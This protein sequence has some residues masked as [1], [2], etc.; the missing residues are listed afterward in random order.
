MPWR[1]VH[2]RSNLKSVLCVPKSKQLNIVFFFALAYAL[3][4]I[5]LRPICPVFLI[6]LFLFTLPLF[7]S[8]SCLAPLCLLSCSTVTWSLQYYFG[9]GNAETLQLFEILLQVLSRLSIWLR[10]M[11]PVLFYWPSETKKTISRRLVISFVESPM[12]SLLPFFP[13]AHRPFC[14]QP[15]LI[16]VCSSYHRKKLETLKWNIIGNLNPNVGPL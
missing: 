4:G 5:I 13:A 1:L 8:L 15:L 12:I 14:I 16:L 2:T 11:F 3:F 9:F 7:S 10:K 6:P